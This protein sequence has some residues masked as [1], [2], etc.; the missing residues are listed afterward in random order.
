MSNIQTNNFNEI[1]AIKFLIEMR[2]DLIEKFENMIYD[3]VERI[4]ILNSL[5]N[6]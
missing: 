1:N 4:L 3:E 5:P 6:L 2:E